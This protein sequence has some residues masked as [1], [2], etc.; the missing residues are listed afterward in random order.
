MRKSIPNTGSDISAYLKSAVAPLSRAEESILVKRAQDG[1]RRAE[2]I[3]LRSNLRLI[4]NVAR[5][6][7][8]AKTPL[9]DLVSEGSLGFREGLRRFKSDSGLKLMSYSIWWVR[10]RIQRYHRTAEEDVHVPDNVGHAQRR[11]YREADSAYRKLVNKRLSDHDVDFLL[12]DEVHDA[13]VGV[14]DTSYAGFSLD[15]AGLSG[16]DQE[17]TRYDY[18]SGQL[19]MDAVDDDYVMNTDIVYDVVKSAL[20]KIEFDVFCR[21]YGLFGKGE[22]TLQEIGITY[23]ITRERARQLLVRAC[24]RIESECRKRGLSDI[25]NLRELTKAWFR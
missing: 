5:R 7:A 10:Q 13:I 16:L 17:E 12:S 20:P 6:Y 23:S 11:R 9:S 1:D 24:K 21:A 14:D 18:V 19:H 22:S 15:A 3:L 2:D 8:S 25:R 4:I